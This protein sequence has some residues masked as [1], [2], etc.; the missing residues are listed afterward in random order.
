MQRDQ[1]KIR[2]SILQ[3]DDFEVTGQD[4][5]MHELETIKEPHIEGEVCSTSVTSHVE[6]NNQQ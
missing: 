2:W 3:E 5:E 1:K 6:G 4:L